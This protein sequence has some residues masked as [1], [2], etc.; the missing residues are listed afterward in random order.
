MT[1]A[2]RQTAQA[3]IAARTERVGDGTAY[4]AEQFTR[5]DYTE[6]TMLAQANPD[7][8]RELAKAES[9]SRR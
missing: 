8:Y 9:E 3:R 5:A 7:R 4:T 1:N 6:R 2:T